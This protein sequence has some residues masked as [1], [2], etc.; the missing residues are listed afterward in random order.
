LLLLLWAIRCSIPLWRPG[1]YRMNKLS[2]KALWAFVVCVAASL[3]LIV[4][5]LH[6]W[7]AAEVRADPSEVIFLT[8]VAIVWLIL[9][10]RLF[11][12]FGLSFNDDVLDRNNASALVALCGG[13][14]SAAIIYAGGSFGEGP[15]FANNFFSAGLGTAGF[16]VLW[17]LLEIGGKVSISIAEERDLASGIRLCGFLVAIGLVLGRAV[18]GD[19]HSTSATVHDFVK[20][21]W[22]AAGICAIALVTERFVRPSRHRPF[23]SWPSSGLIPALLYLALAGAWL[24]HEGPWEGMPR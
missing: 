7:G 1:D 15:S 18:A 12:W 24:G 20:D 11:S 17:I 4:V 13:V 14:L 16:L 2:T 22:P 21:G 9:T 19:W 6:W 3:F 5:G 8:F 23:P 10:T